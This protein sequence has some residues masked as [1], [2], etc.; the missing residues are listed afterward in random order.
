M[1][2]RQKLK[3]RNITKRQKNTKIPKNTKSRKL[4]K[5]QKNIKTRIFTKKRNIIKGGANYIVPTGGINYEELDKAYFILYP[6]EGEHY[7]TNTFKQYLGTGTNALF[8]L[9]QHIYASPFDIILKRFIELNVLNETQQNLEHDQKMKLIGAIIITFF[10]NN[11]Q[12]LKS[13]DA[14]VDRMTSMNKTLNKIALSGC[15]TIGSSIIGKLTNSTHC[16]ALHHVNLFISNNRLNDIFNGLYIDAIR[17]SIYDFLKSFIQL[18]NFDNV[19]LN[20]ESYVDMEKLAVPII[21]TQ[22]L[23]SIHLP[24]FQMPFLKK[25]LSYSNQSNEQPLQ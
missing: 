13:G 4:K 19:V 16:I 11:I 10:I 23:P 9:T 1:K 2:S 17:Q 20:I 6:N 15:D 7:F 22:H 12:Y 14:K 24:S 3:K 5:R 21:K 18:P 25:N 8:N